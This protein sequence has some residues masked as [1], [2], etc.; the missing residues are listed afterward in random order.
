MRF[1]GPPSKGHRTPA[2]NL[3]SLRAL[4]SA[5]LRR[6]VGPPV[7]AQ[8]GGFCSVRSSPSTII[9][10]RSRGYGR[11]SC[12]P[13]QPPHR[14]T[15]RTALRFPRLGESPMHRPP[16]TEYRVRRLNV[17]AARRRTQDQAPRF[18]TQRFERA[19]CVPS[20]GKPKSAACSFFYPLESEISGRLFDLRFRSM[21][22]LVRDSFD[23]VSEER[24][25]RNPD[26]PSA[27]TS[28]F[29]KGGADELAWDSIR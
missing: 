26:L 13:R 11:A 2:S 14:R 4:V 5:D 1:T 10:E 7:S 17:R 25:K 23:Q 6:V 19:T 16:P 18:E 8:P 9:P 29:G 15:R 20:Q 24:A 12:L 27:R 22:L 28:G 21:P 3:L